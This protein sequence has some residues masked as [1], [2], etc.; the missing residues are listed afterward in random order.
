[1]TWRP[2]RPLGHGWRKKKRKKKP[3]RED[4]PMPQRSARPHLHPSIDA[5]RVCDAVERDDMTGF[6]VECGAETETVEPDAERYTCP[7][8]DAP[9]VYGAET[10]LLWFA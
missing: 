2:A 7:E 3:T 10:V 5:D 9:A 6:C 4:D 1:M 8:C